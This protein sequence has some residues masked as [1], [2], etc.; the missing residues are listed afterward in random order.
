M[1]DSIISTDIQEIIEDFKDIIPS[2]ENKTILL[3]GGRGFLGTYFL[4]TFVR[5]NELLKNPMKILV[6]D[7]LIT[8]K[9]NATQYPNV[10]FI[11]ADI[12]KKL[13]VDGPIN[14]IIHAAS[15]AS[16]LIYRK[17]PIKTIDV[18]YQGTRNLLDIAKEKNI[19]AMLYLSSSEI[20]G[21]PK[22]V[23]TPET[24]WGNVSCNGPRA[25]YDE[26]KRLAETIC[27]TYYNQYRIPVKIARPFNSYGPLLRLDDGRVIPDFFK[28]AL[29]K[30]KI[31]LH[32]DGTPT[33]SFCYVSDSIRGFLKILFYATPG[34]IYNVG[35]DQ[36]IS[37]RE[38]AE[39]VKSMV[40]SV[41][42]VYEKSDD[43]DYNTDSPRKR[44]PDLAKI[45][46]DLNYFPKVSLNEGLK[47]VHNWYKKELE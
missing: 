17:F 37:M 28:N 46:Q 30:S 24:Y 43:T 41:E 25:C 33:R 7:N 34:S 42:I 39:R 6:F 15:I 10:T 40:G 22:I 9:D 12:S 14:Y 23:P 45:K 19:D 16:P 44:I 18:N 4:R 38:L 47:R 3:T 5:I 27:L 1:N 36:E 26:S 29:Q 11:E 2:F 35:N 21:D 13:E 31:I 8:S 32:S 20:Y